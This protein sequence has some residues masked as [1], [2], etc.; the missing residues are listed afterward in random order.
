MSVTYIG[1]DLKLILV[2]V[3]PKSWLW[4]IQDKGKEFRP[5]IAKHCGVAASV[6]QCIKD[7]R[8]A[9]PRGAIT[10]VYMDRRG[11]RDEN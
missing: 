11:L 9:V 7:S 8:K 5:E 1:P 4:Y 3:S 2:Q 6:R 10:L